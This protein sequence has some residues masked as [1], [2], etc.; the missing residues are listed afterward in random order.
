MTQINF[1][2]EVNLIELYEGPIIK[3]TISSVQASRKKAPRVFPP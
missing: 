1:Y 2:F 3:K